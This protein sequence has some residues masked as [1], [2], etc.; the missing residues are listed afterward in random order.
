[1]LFDSV[2]L[3]YAAREGAIWVSYPA[4]LPTGE[5]PYGAGFPVGAIPPAYWSDPPNAVTA[6]RVA[7]WRALLGPEASQSSPAT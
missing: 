2:G 1:M 4:R 3:G 5:S 6:E 7:L